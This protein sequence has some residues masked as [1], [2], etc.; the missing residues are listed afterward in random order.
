MIQI[1][2][3]PLQL[4]VYLVKTFD[5]VILLKEKDALCSS[6]MLFGFKEGLST[7]EFIYNARKNIISQF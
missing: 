6:D 5:W 3:G 1:I 2:T 4:V 7:T